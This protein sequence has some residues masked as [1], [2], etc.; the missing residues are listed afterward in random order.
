MLHD[1]PMTQRRWRDLVYRSRPCESGWLWT[2]CSSLLSCLQG[3][4][5][6]LG[7]VWPDGIALPASSICQG[8]L[9]RSREKHLNAPE[10]TTEPDIKELN[11]AILSG[12]S[13]LDAGVAGAEANVNFSRSTV[14]HSKS[15]TPSVPAPEGRPSGWR[16][17]YLP[18]G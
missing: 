13:M 1:C 10:L 5:P 3:R 4:T 11:I 16:C 6:L 8:L 7:R 17:R 2:F 15:T 9:H 12:R 18:S 14:Q